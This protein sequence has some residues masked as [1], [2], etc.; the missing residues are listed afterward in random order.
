MLAIAGTEWK[1]LSTVSGAIF[2]PATWM[3][4]KS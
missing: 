4:L 3:P 2:G 1:P